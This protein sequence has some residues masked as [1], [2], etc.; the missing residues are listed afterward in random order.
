MDR[1]DKKRE[2]PRKEINNDAQMRKKRNAGEKE[3]AGERK[4]NS[5]KK[6]APPKKHPT[7]TLSTTAI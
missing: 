5:K 4:E 2:E 7:I 3:K 1:Q 6:Q